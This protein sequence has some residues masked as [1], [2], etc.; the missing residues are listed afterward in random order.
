MR[1]ILTDELQSHLYLKSFWCES[2][3]APYATGQQE[4]E[5]PST[6]HAFAVT[7]NFLCGSP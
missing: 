5:Y 3:W 7:L 1:D 4:R 2:R 6:F